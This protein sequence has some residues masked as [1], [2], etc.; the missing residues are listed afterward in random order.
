MMT[1]NEDLKKLDD[2][3]CALADFSSKFFAL[4]GKLSQDVIKVKQFD[5]FSQPLKD[6][7]GKQIEQDV[8]IDVVSEKLEPLIFLA[9]KF[10]FV[11]SN[12]YFPCTLTFEGSKIKIKNVELMIDID[13]DDIW[14]LSAKKAQELKK[15]RG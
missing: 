14:D 7:K 12:L 8:F 3:V 5:K 4:H 1:A 10:G 15:L 2:T 11:R 13:S 9:E 6:D